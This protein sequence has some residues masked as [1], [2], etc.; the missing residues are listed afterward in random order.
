MASEI[1]TVAK[2][3]KLAPRKNPYWISVGGGRGGVSLGYRKGAHP[4]G[5]W[6]AKIV[7]NRQRLEEKLGVADDEG[8][9]LG[10]LSYKSAVVA[11]IGWSAQQNA[12]IVSSEQSEDRGRPTV[13]SA[14]EAYSKHRVKRSQRSGSN[15]QGRLAKHVLSDSEF[16]DTPLTKLRAVNIQNWRDRL[17][18]AEGSNTIAGGRKMA[19]ATINRL[20]NDFRAALNAAYEGHRRELPAHFPA[21]VSIGTRA[22]P[23]T[24][25][26]RQQLLSDEMVRAAV[27]VAFEIEDEGH[28]GRLVMLAASTGARYSQLAA[29]QVGHV[30]PSLGRVLIPGSKKG[31]SPRAKPP[32]AFPVSTDVL[33]KLA[34]ALVGRSTDEP[35]LTRWAYRNVG[36][37]K[38]EKDR[39]RPLGSA[40]EIEKQWA[41]VVRRADLP[42]KTIMYALRHSS[43][44]RGLRTGLPVR[45]VASLHDTSIEMIE[46]HYSAFIVDMTED[47]ARRAAISFSH[48]EV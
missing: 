25:L 22:L 1:D 3:A 37:F 31:R 14:V 40:Y 29:M 45:L 7:L 34:P 39:L 44:V 32:V 19:P 8:S 15:A 21:E 18:E 23:S 47:L 11:A 28:F 9:D 48:P 30:Q 43:I 4:P 12:A 41:E 5:A 42:P 17:G 46:K 10:A 36:P 27:S 26:A 16:A 24:S 33:E 13:R 2:R 38:W 6:V 35:L 20:M